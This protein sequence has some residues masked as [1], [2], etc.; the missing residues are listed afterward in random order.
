M[1]ESPY[2]EV[3]QVATVI[4]FAYLLVIIPALGV[5]ENRLIHWQDRG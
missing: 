4:Y 2:L 5:I 1:P 3:G